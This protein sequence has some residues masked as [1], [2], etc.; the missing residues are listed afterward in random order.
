M[1]GGRRGIS[2]RELL[3]T[4]AV[5]G[6][7]V[8]MAGLFGCATGTGDTSNSGEPTWTEETDFVVVGSG[9]GVFAGM[10][11]AK[12]GAACVVLEK[13]AAFGGTTFV[14]GGGAWMPGNHLRSAEQL[15]ED[16]VEDVVKYI[17]AVDLYGKMEEDNIRD[18]L[19]NGPAVFKYINE[20]LGVPLGLQTFGGLDYY[21]FPGSSSSRT[22]LFLDSDGQGTGV[23][24]WNEGVRP[25]VESL[26]VDIRLSTTA[27]SLYTD[28]S[29]AV[30]GVAATGPD[31][32]LAIKANKGVLLAAGGFDNDATMRQNYLRG[33][34]VGS[35]AVLENTG[36]GHKM[37][38]ALGA[39]IGNMDAVWGS[40]FFKVDDSGELSRVIDPVPWRGQA[41]SIIVNAH[42]RRIVN[43]AGAYDGVSNA[44][45]NT[46]FGINPTCGAFMICDATYVKYYG[47]PGANTA[48]TLDTA[49]PKPDYVKEYDTLEALA[50]DNGID[51]AGLALEVARVNAMAATGVDEDFHRGESAYE[52]GGPALFWA[53]VERPDLKN[54]W[55]GPIETAPFYV[56]VTGAGS[57]GTSGGLKVNASAQVLKNGEPIPGLYAA[58]CNAAAFSGSAYSSAGMS[59]VGTIYRSVAAANHALALGIF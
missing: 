6:A 32:E 18:W 55:F 53:G 29:G 36:D 33:P 2:R 21:S 9:G 15:A 45:W 14:S 10:V 22:I 59:V 57:W 11:A 25:I 42:G 43:E 35:V 4:S 56:A 54:R 1:R 48:M 26:G 46:N 49:A 52:I 3:K 58:G 30:I 44:M 13:G 39:D 50:A 5:V 51:A 31:G 23:K 24:A 28:A 19:R 40:N 7:G 8:A 47:F 20:T 37:G 12:A 16:G 34:L 17:K 38:M 41:N 27:T